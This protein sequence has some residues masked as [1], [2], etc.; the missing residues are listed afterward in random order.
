MVS[1]TAGA[2]GAAGSHR[3]YTAGFDEGFDTLAG[4]RSAASAVEDDGVPASPPWA[5]LSL[6]VVP[7][8]GWAGSGTL[9]LRFRLGFAASDDAA[10]ALRKTFCTAGS[11]PSVLAAN[12][13]TAVCSQR[14]G[15][16]NLIPTRCLNPNPHRLKSDSQ[17]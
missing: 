5:A 14:P 3:A 17:T 11:Q 6:L 4:L 10:Q 13:R 1:V 2:L 8:T 9:A 15:F 16:L 7:A 12:V